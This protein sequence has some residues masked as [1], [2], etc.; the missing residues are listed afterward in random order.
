MPGIYTLRNLDD[1]DRLHAATRTAKRAVIVGGGFIGIEMAENLLRRGVETTL[2]EF[3]KQILGPWDA[4]MVAPVAEF[5]CAKG[6]RLRL[7]DAAEQFT[8]HDGGLRVSLKSGD[9]LDTDFVVLAIG[10]RPENELAK[11]AGLD[12][13]E[14]G[15]HPRQRPHADQRRQHLRGGGCN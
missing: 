1:A 10:V 4:E 13:A 14:R 15:G 5:L 6:L 12:V 2:V 7:G 3:N 11:Q 9:S 8:P